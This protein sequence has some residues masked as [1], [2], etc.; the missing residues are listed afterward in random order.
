MVLNIKI[1]I[2][3]ISFN[4][5]EELLNTIESVDKQITLP[6]EHII[7]DGSTNTEIKEFLNGKIQ[8]NYRKW[9]SEPDQGISDAFNKGVIN[10][11][12][13]FMQ[14]LNSGDTL[15]NK[16]TIQEVQAELQQSPVCKW[17]HGQLQL[18]RGGKQV[19]I[20]KPFNPQK[21][22]RGMRSTFHPAMFVHKNLFEK[23]G[24]FS[25][26]YKIAMDYDFLIRIRKE[27]FKFMPFPIA[28]FNPDGIS[29]SNYLEGL[30]E[31]KKIYKKYCGNNF[32]L[33]LWQ[34][35]LKILHYLLQSKVGKLLYKIKQKLGLANI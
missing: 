23:Y 2:I 16:S 21:I 29:N 27:P 1:S 5:K 13:D 32:K 25:M 14:F 31:V 34:L 24:N 17:M 30:K 18:Q 9:I 33:T 15:Y 8:P 10:A 4:N 22:Y 11:T 20:G 26:Q 12:G 19:I 6:Y 28:I 3:T 7:I 35:R